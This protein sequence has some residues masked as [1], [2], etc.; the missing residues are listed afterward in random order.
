M[1]MDNIDA[2]PTVE[3]CDVLIVTILPEEWDSFKKVFPEAG[4]INALT[5]FFGTTATKLT[6]FTYCGYTCVAATLNSLRAESK[7]Q[8]KV[9]AAVFTSRL[10]SRFSPSYLVNIGIAARVGKDAC[11]IGGVVIAD[12]LYDLGN[13]A[14]IQD[15]RRGF[16][17]QPA[18]D[19]IGTD[20]TVR[21]T[22]VQAEHQPPPPLQQWLSEV[23]QNLQ[24]RSQSGVDVISHSEGSIVSGEAVAKATAFRRLIQDV[25]RGAHAYEM[26]SYAIAQTAKLL[27]RSLL[28][29][30]GSPIAATRERMPSKTA[31]RAKSGDSQVNMRIAYCASLLS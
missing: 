28:Y 4:E 1:A 8:G 31:R 19:S 5:G 21:K 27:P 11:G 3:Q 29:L 30:K 25:N 9:P 12:N 2:A 7:L 13:C 23:R 6:R 10:L 15:G 22:L 26:E 16:R 17:F 24:T 20:W 18:T 14:I